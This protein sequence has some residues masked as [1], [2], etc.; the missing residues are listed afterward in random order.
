MNINNTSIIS[1]TLLTR[2]FYTALALI[3][4]LTLPNFDKSSQYFLEK[5][6]TFFFHHIKNHGYTAEHHLAFFPLLPLLGKYFNL[7]LP[8]KLANYCINLFINCI[9]SILVYK[10]STHFL[11]PEISEYSLYFF[12]FNPVSIVMCA[13]YTES[14]FAL[15]FLLC[16]YCIINEKYYISVLMISLSCICRSNGIIFVYLILRKNFIQTVM[17]VITICVPISI[18]QLYCISKI[19]KIQYKNF[20]FLKNDLLDNILMY[21]IQLRLYIPYTYL[22]KKYWNQGF[23]KFY[24]S[25][26]IPN[27]LIGLP[28]IISSLY[29]VH[30]GYKIESKNRDL[31]KKLCFILQVQTILSI[32]CLHLNMY[33]RF[34]SYNPII[35][36]MMGYFY[37]YGKSRIMKVYMRFYLAFGVA[38]AT[39]FGAFYPPA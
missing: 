27:L 31:F 6:D 23:L 14:L 13:F 7:F 36:M 11:D 10:I 35:Y 18:F 21:K 29:I 33:F 16:L 30:W 38:Y 39:L 22:Q 37:K 19:F 5:W 28:F 24:T 4:H 15:L 1:L 25:N 9:N 26:N 12:L 20:L 17:S 34:V 8:D 2:L 3:S 32:F